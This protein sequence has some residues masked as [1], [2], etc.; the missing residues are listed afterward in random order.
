MCP[1]TKCTRRILAVARTGAYGD[2]MAA[3]PPRV[4]TVPPGT[5]RRENVLLRELVAV[6]SHLSALASQDRVVDGVVRLV[7]RRTRGN[8][9]VVGARSG[10]EPD[11]LSA[12]PPGAGERSTAAVGAARL[13][14]VLGAAAQNRRAV[15]LSA[16]GADGAGVVIVPVLVGHDVAGHL[17]AA[18]LDPSGPDREGELGD[19]LLL[20][21]AEHAATVC[22]IILGRERVVAA[23]MTTARPSGGPGTSGSRGAASTTC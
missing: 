9:A 6:Y 5:D 3:A 22:G 10:S 16:M 7:A 18:R 15:S 12:A 23:T 19:D 11:V 13:A 1:N 2:A 8:V 17:M 21:L 4:P 14:A 20:L